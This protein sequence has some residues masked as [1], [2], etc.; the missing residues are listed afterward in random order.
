MISG[1]IT[2]CKIY[3]DG[4]EEKVL[5]RSNFITAGLGSSLS[6]LLEGKGSHNVDDYAPGYF[7]VG[8]GSIGYTGVATSA[9][10]YQLSTP[11]DWQDYGRDTDQ[12]VDK[13]Y[14][15]FV[16][17]SDDGGSTYNEMLLTSA[18]YS[19][20]IYSGIFFRIRNYLR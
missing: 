16:A 17:S 2:I 5:N 18:T 14:R 19:S 1:H 20:T 9:Y 11:F 7:Q 6:D 3:K 15:C 13:R 8:T 12:E 10:F 4:T